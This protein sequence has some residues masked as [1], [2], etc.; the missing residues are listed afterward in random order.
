MSYCIRYS[1]SE[2]YTPME[3]VQRKYHVLL[4]ALIIMAALAI[5]HFYPQC[6]EYA[7]DLLFPGASES[8]EYSFEELSDAIQAGEPIGAALNTFCQN[9]INETKGV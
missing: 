6:S 4:G 9:V 3:K 8:L 2:K 5:Q 7:R 1:G